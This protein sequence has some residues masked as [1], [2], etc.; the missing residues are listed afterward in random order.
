[1]WIIPNKIGIYFIFFLI[2]FYTVSVCS[3]YLSSQRKKKKVLKTL[4]ID[5][6]R[7]V[8]SHISELYYINIHIF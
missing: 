5:D 7:W 1:M 3:M 4:R 2:Y 8:I 6:D